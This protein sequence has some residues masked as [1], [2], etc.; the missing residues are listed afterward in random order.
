MREKRQMIQVYTFLL[1]ILHNFKNKI[2]IG[3][4]EPDPNSDDE[5]DTAAKAKSLANEGFDGDDE[6]SFKK[7]CG[8]QTDDDIN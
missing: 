6:E 7:D 5:E 1:L 8:V 3:I 2:Y 4:T